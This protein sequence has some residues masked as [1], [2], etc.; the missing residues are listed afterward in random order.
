EDRHDVADSVALGRAYR[1]RANAAQSIGAVRDA[2][3]DLGFTMDLLREA[4]RRGCVD[5]DAEIL[6]ASVTRAYALLDSERYE[7][8]LRDFTAA[9]SLGADAKDLRP[10]IEL[11]RMDQ[12]GARAC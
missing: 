8:A 3:C 10:A 12:E 4:T 5:L 6:E 1:C 2:C 9:V 7:E 11:C